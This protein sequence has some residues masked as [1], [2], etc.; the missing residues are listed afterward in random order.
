[1]QPWHLFQEFFFSFDMQR[2]GKKHFTCN[3]VIL[4]YYHFMCSNPRRWHF[5][6]FGLQ[7]LL[8]PSLML[9]QSYSWWVL[10]PCQ[11][12]G[13]L[14]EW[15]LDIVCRFWREKNIA[16]SNW[17][18]LSRHNTLS[19]E[20]VLHVHKF[21]LQKLWISVNVVILLKMEL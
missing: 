12:S 7:R 2:G 10:L 21:T 13:S 8:P 18:G 4:S 15:C 6:V 1:M 17:N 11:R 9:L 3:H 14:D 19:K 5:G 20:H 16:I